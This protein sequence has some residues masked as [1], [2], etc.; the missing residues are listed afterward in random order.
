MLDKIQ[1]IIMTYNSPACKELQQ[2]LSRMGVDWRFG[3]GDYEIDVARN[4]NVIRF[5]DEDVPRGKEYMFMLNDDMVPLLE[6]KP[7]LEVPGDIV[8]C[9]SVAN[10]GRKDHFGDKEFS[11]AC[12]RVHRKVFQSF[13]P[14]WFK[15][16]HSGDVTKR[17]YCDCNY[18]RDRANDNGFDSKMVGIVGHSQRCILIPDGPDKWKMIWPNAWDIHNCI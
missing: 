7:I 4:L 14:P 1:C 2:W 5:L 11:G 12:F 13:G 17:T 6:T 15:V 16:G 9:G 8:Y 3:I 10:Y 18:F